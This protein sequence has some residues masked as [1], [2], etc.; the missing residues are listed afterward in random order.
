MS[1]AKPAG[2]HSSQVSRC[3]PCHPVDSVGLVFSAREAAQAGPHSLGVRAGS[4][5]A[6]VGSAVV[7]DELHVRSALGY[8]TDQGKVATQPEPQ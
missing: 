5:P 3:L 8:T 7:G 2:P 6:A 4:E 1:A